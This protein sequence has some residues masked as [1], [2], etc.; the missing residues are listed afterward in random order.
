MF[1]I[2]GFLI[3]LFALGGSLGGGL[4]GIVGGALLGGMVASLT[5]EEPT[6]QPA[7]PAAQP[8]AAGPDG[9]PTPAPTQAVDGHRPEPTSGQESGARFIIDWLIRL[10][11]V[12]ALG[13][14]LYDRVKLEIAARKVADAIEKQ[15]G[16]D[17]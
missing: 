1:A 7:T 6:L 14:Y 13:T 12:A 9:T 3:G 2:V 4:L 5:G 16:K 15:A 10:M 11:L 8:T 17:R